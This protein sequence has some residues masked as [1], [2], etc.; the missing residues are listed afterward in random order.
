M[1]AEEALRI[2]NEAIFTKSNQYLNDLESDLL[3]ACWNGESYKDLASRTNYTI[4]YIK[5]VAA[6]FWKE[7]LSVALGEPVSLKNF[8][9]ALERYKQKQVT[10]Q[11]REMQSDWGEAPDVPVLY[12]REKELATLEQ[13]IITDRCRLV[14]IVGMAGIGKTRLVRGGIG[15]TDLSLTLA[16]R[17]QA[18]F[19]YIIWRR[20]LS[21]PP[22]EKILADFIEFLSGHAETQLPE[23]V[24]GQVTKLLLYLRQHRCL[25]ILDNV[26]SILC[27]GDRAGQYREGFEGYGDLFRRIGESAHQS[28]LLLTS[29]EQPQEIAAMTGV[30]PVRLLGLA[31]LNLQA[32]QRIFADISCAEGASF[33][34]SD[35]DWEAIV[36]FYSGNPLALE[37]VARYILEWFGGN[38]AEFAQQHLTAVD[39][40]RTL[41]D[42]HFDRLSDA[43]QEIMYWLAINREPVTVSDLRDDVVSP[44]AKQQILETLNHLGRQLPLEKSGDRFTL[45]PVLIEYV[46]DRLIKLVCN[47]IETKE[48]RLF[49]SHALMKASAQDYVRDTQV[50]LI[51]K[52]IIGQ[53]IA[54]L[55]LKGEGCLEHQLNQILHLLRERYQHRPGYAGGNLLNLLCQLGTDVSSYDFSHLT[56]WQAYLQGI[57]LDRVNFAYCDFART[58]FTQSFGGVH[59]IAFS[60]DGELVAVGDSNG[61]I[62]LFQTKDEQQRSILRGHTKSLWVTSVAFSPNGRMILSCSLDHTV[63]LWNVQSGECL[64]TFEGHTNWL[65]TVAF[66]PDG[67]TVASGGD[68]QTARLWDIATGESKILADHQGWVWSVTFSPDGQFL[69]TGSYDKTIRLWNVSTGQCLEVLEGHENSVWS[70]AFSPDGQILASGSLDGTVKFWKICTGECLNTLKG[71]SKE[72]RSIAFSSD[73]QI[74]ASGSFDQTIRLWNAHT[75]EHLKTLKGHM[76]GIRILAFNTAN[77]TL[78]SGDN[79]QVLKLWNINT[80]ECLKTLR[81]HSNWTWTLAFSPDGKTLASGSL[82]QMVRIWDISGAKAR[83]DRT[84]EISKVLRGHTNWVWSVAF[85][86]DGKIIASSSDDETIK[87]WDASTGQCLK[88]LQGHIKGGVW[89]VAFSPDGQTVASGGQDGT[90]RFWDAYTGECLN[91]LQGHSNWIWSVA[92]SPDGQTLVSGSDDETIKLWNADTGQC[93]L[94][95]Q[96]DVGRVMSVAFSPDGQTL[97]SGNDDAKAKVWDVQTGQCIRT[98]KGH[99]GWVLSVAFS[100]DGQIVA[101]AGT[102]ETIRLWSIRN[103]ECIKV[104]QRHAN[105]VRSIAFAPNGQTLAS[106]GTDGTIQLWDVQTGNNS[107]TLQPKRPYEGV[108]IIEVTGLTNAEKETLIALGAVEIAD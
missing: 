46:T 15:K 22:P 17:I 35:Q 100:P 9:Q 90:V 71:H 104:L 49:N 108:N 105:W 59:S 5:E 13:W 31:G 93:L 85:S 107:L 62:R 53:L 64:R 67:K 101:S 18:E 96:K 60:P 54:K 42:W 70:L 39:K 34:G 7:S 81:G 27:G 51:L 38:I 97:V 50:R 99:T 6:K 75:G 41:L 76:N 32:G 28:C 57:N 44:L 45:Q 106:C 102:D 2:A 72:V 91:C 24:E 52:V 14:S 10:A 98:F 16:H 61:D 3:K 65:W 1:D 36:H 78:A 40:I 86:P 4:D 19:D 103:G 8:K 80:G 23:T 30:Q 83:N 79:Y 56:I 66:S 74:L 29:R 82:D 33:Y 11:V 20:L 26:E 69:A 25:L 58:V 12:G 84:Q 95:L 21:T 68:D 89:S 94:L 37:V 73:G 88:T 92:F 87:L 55:G 48:I 43:E 63:K 77:N 47:E